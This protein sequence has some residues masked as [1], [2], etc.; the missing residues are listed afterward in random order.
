M[1]LQGS[2]EAAKD[3][4]GDRPVVESEVCGENHFRV[5]VR[6]PSQD[7][8]DA[9]IDGLRQRGVSVIGLSRRRVTLEDAFLGIL[10]ASKDGESE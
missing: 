4:V 6:V 3:G 1:E 10:S 8:V 7:E 5:V 2:G 9:C